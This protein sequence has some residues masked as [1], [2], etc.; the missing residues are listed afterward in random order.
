MHDR[1]VT[2]Y[3]KMFC[4]FL[5]IFVSWADKE[6]ILMLKAYAHMKREY[7]S[8]LRFYGEDPSATWIDDFFSTFAVFI[9]DFE[10]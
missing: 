9:S 4:Y 2:Y 8:V 10:V 7:S 3:Y 5:K 6:M 1:P